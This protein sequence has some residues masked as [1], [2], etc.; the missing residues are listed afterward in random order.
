MDNFTSVAAKVLG[1]RIR[2]RRENLGLSQE[3]VAH[4]SS[5]HVSNFGKIERG[6]ANPSLHTMLRIASVLEVDPGV[7]IAGLSGDMVTSRPHKL[8]AA[9]LIR[10]RQ[11]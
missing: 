10:A 1:E 5:M 2:E 11:G 7:L 6:L 9:E 3:D 8:T 4:L